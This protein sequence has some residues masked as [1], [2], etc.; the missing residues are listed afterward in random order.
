MVFN[1]CPKRT[2]IYIYYIYVKIDLRICY[3][4]LLKSM[5][6]HM[7][8]RC[9]NSFYLFLSLLSFWE[10]SPD[11][12]LSFMVDIST[13]RRWPF[14]HWGVRPWRLLL[15]H[16]LVFPESW[17]DAAGP[18]RSVSGCMMYDIYI[19]LHGCCTKNRGMFPP[20]MD[21]ENNG[22]KP[23]LKWMI[24]GVKTP[25]FW[26]HL[27]GDWWSWIWYDLV[28][29]PTISWIIWNRKSAKDSMIRSAFFGGLVDS[30]TFF[31]EG[32]KGDQPNDD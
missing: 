12:L 22:S 26:K 13:A 8:T 2:L 18:S 24:W 7:K 21:G 1:D 28:V 25:Y 23:Y 20:K 31:G 9:I 3:M 15:Q 10:N 30:L 17:L 4:S 16:V 19:A 6:K 29:T 27:H 11:W 32:W 14:E 5:K